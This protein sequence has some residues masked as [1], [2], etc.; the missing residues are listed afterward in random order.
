MKFMWTKDFIDEVYTA[1]D[2]E[3]DKW[4]VFSTIKQENP[5]DKILSIWDQ[6]KSDILPALRSWIDGFVISWPS[7]LSF[8]KD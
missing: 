5:S 1:E 2:Y 3:W 8:V 4:N 7:E 6:E